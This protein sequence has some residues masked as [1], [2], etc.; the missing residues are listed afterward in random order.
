MAKDSKAQQTTWA[1]GYVRYDSKGKATFYIRAMR[2]GVRYDL[3]TRAHDERSAH[4][5]LRRFDSD[6]VEYAAWLRGEGGAS[7]ETPIYLDQALRDEFIA[8]SA[9]PKN[10]GGKENTPEWQK[11]QRHELEWWA[12]RLA[13]A[14]GHALDLRKVAREDVFR[15]LDGPPKVGGVRKKQAVL[16]SLYGWLRRHRRGVR[17]DASEDPLA[18]VPNLP[19]GVA[20]ANGV[21]KYVPP[22]NVHAVIDDLV[23]RGSVYGHALCVQAGT[24]WHVKELL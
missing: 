13:D 20:Q 1:G 2:G 8:W 5:H 14:K 12:V 7:S 3:S 17:I 18:E 24:G 22:A 16:K 9:A 6:P 19:G 15:V 10:E 11:Y 23:A 4:D 21:D